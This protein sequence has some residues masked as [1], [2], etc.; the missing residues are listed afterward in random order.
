MHYLLVGPSKLYCNLVGIVWQY[1]I[2]NVKN[3]ELKDIQREIHAYNYSSSG[4]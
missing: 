1:T 3:A 4:V 2:R